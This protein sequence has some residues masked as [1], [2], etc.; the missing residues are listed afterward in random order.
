MFFWAKGAAYWFIA[1]ICKDLF[2]FN[3][4]LN[5]LSY[6]IITLYIK[7]TFSGEVSGSCWQFSSHF[8]FGL[9]WD[10][11]PA[12]NISQQMC[13]IRTVISNLIDR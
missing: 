1:K 12:L 4:P 8:R 9:E 10:E 5:S 6:F 7:N 3:L 2:Y 13:Y 11:K